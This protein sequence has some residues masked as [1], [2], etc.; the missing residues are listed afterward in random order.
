MIDQGFE[1]IWKVSGAKPSFQPFQSK[2]IEDIERENWDEYIHPVWDEATLP[3]FGDPSTIPESQKLLSKAL[4]AAAKGSEAPTIILQHF[5]AFIKSGEAVGYYLFT[6]ATAASL[7]AASHQLDSEARRYITLWGEGYVQYWPCY[8]VSSLMCH[9]KT[10]KLLLE[11]L[12]TP[13]LGFKK[14]E[15]S[16]Q[17]DQLRSTLTYR[18]KHGRQL[19][20]GH[21]P[22]SA[23]LERTSLLAIAKGNALYTQDVI[24]TKWLGSSGATE[25]KIKDAEQ[26]LQVTLP[27][28]YKSF[29]MQSNGF[30]PTT[31]VGVTILPVQQIDYLT[32]DYY[33]MVEQWATEGYRD[34]N[35]VAARFRSSILIGGLWEEQ[36]LL[37]VPDE[38]GGW[39]CWFFALWSAGET[40]YP[41]FRYYIESLLKDLEDALE[42]HET[43]QN[44]T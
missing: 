30:K 16:S 37:L 5:D 1:V 40:K 12:L 21:L 26:K 31:S 4:N 27:E 18:V 19:L 10:V 32:K 33:E 13:I 14:G 8:I 44:H 39:E 43:S 20:Y 3:S 24:R 2:S 41:G 28:D 29:L 36:Q 7:F 38:K 34:D 42:G 22:W 11:G 35:D 9:R 23:L 6:V 25:Q 15:L 17:L